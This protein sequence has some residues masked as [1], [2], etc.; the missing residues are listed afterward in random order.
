V[1][2]HPIRFFEKYELQARE[3][4]KEVLDALHKNWPKYKYFVLNLPTGVGK[5]YIAT[6]IA[7]E[8]DASYMLTSTLHLQDQYESSWDEI[9]NLKGRSNYQC[10]V[11]TNFTVDN[12][13][14]LAQPDL[15]KSC[16]QHNICA[17][18]NQKKLALSSKA[19]MTNPVYMLYSVHCGVLKEDGTESPWRRRNA[20]IVDEAHN[21]E[22]HLVSFA[23]SDVTP[24]DYQKDFVVKMD[25]IM[26]TGTF[27]DYE[28]IGI[29]KD[30][31]VNKQ[32]ELQEQLENEFP[33]AHF[34]NDARQWAKGIDK[35]VADRVNKL[36]KKLNVLDK[37]IQP[38]KIFFNTH[39]SV[40]EL[41]A[42]WMIEKVQDE[43]IVKLA[44][45]YGDFLFEEYMDNLAE[46]F[47]FL[48]AT[49]GSKTQFCKELGIKEEECFY[50][51]TDSPFDPMKSPIIV[52]GNI[53]LSRDKKEK[54]IKKLGP[55][56]EEILAQHPNDRGIIHSVTYDIAREIFQQVK[57]E[58]RKRLLTRDMDAFNG[59]KDKYPRR[60]SNVEL[61]ELHDKAKNT[62]LLS[63]SMMEGVDL[64]GDLSK[65]Q[66]IIKLPWANLGNIRVK[67][68]T[69]LDGDWYANKMWLNMMQASGRST[70]NEQDESVTYILDEKFM[71]FFGQWKRNLPNWFKN[72]IVS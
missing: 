52:V 24:I 28:L 5:T 39:G 66:I 36:S 48:S 56:V 72:R 18:Y 35:K 38:L 14:C 46:K 49:L 71:W 26:F 40:E 7:N 3:Q 53:N 59:S 63:P 41:K 70:R 57:P 65:F 61:L 1:K 6:S 20:L 43:N 42:R 51:E 25:D 45:I 50:M 47:V 32:Q 33:P 2:Q 16:I 67:R 22:G 9:I 60:Y 8:L 69:E 30:R 58:D 21:L 62:V 23:E 44:P 11:N 13:P 10:N 64:Y 34:G 37:M 68:K 12:A 54:N 31:L 4:Q 29:I 27:K 55:I 19:M 15:A 17:Y